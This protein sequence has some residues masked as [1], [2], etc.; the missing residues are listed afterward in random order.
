LE[1]WNLEFRIW[2]F[3]PPP[4]ILPLPLEGEGIGGGG[5][6]SLCIL[7]CHFVAQPH[8]CFKSGAGRQNLPDNLCEGEIKSII[9]IEEKEELS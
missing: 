3:P 6:N 1:Y 9:D 7:N 5:K 4:V 2:D 8:F